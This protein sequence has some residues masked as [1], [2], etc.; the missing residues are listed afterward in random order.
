MTA[1]R[2]ADA[3]DGEL[4]AGPGAAFH[5]EGRRIGEVRQ[6]GF[7]GGRRVPGRL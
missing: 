4:I 6:V 1:F 7:A 3:A 5:A 2:A